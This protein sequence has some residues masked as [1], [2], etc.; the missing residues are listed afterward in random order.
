MADFDLAIIGGGPGGYVAAIHAAGLGASV[1]LVERRDLGGTCLNRGCIP[2]KTFLETAH[3]LMDLKNAKSFGLK[4]GEVSL[5]VDAARK[6]KERVVRQLRN[7]VKG[8]LRA[9]GVEVV[10]GEGSLAGPTTVTV[11]GSRTLEAKNVILATGSS[12]LI[13]KQFAAE[14]DL[15]IDAERALDMES[16]PRRMA[17]IGGGYV[18][19]EMASIYRAFGSEVVLIEML[20]Q[21]LPTEEEAAA[22]IVG[23][24]LR[25]EGI[26]VVTGIGVKELKTTPDTVTA[27]L[28]DGAEHT[29]DKLLVAVGRVANTAGLNLETA[30][31]S[32]TNG[33][34]SADPLMQTNVR[35]VYA[36]GD[37]VGQPMLAHAAS[38]EGVVAAGNALGETRRMRYNAIPACAYSHPQVARVGVTE[39]EA[40][41]AGKSVK[42]GEFPAAFSGRAKSMKAEE[43][44]AKII[45]DEETNEILGGTL[46]GPVAS[47]MI[48]EL[49]VAIEH[50]LTLECIAET[51]HAHPTLSEMVAEACLHALG[52]PVHRV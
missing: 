25:E 30:G 20:P 48:H 51:V 40:V 17:V 35:G 12:S 22:E 38:A 8:L 26:Q 19:V 16:V 49:A 46:V 23:A 31:V 29:A 45:G 21:I 34:V 9:R 37:L 11:N 18:G 15:V 5:D 24:A 14:S 47:E 43:G 6:N 3:R 42:V 44:F 41:A 1:A 27:V 4:V 33:C 7:G 52:T 50:E 39:K 32:T 36:I 28:A 2:T 10:E 13:P